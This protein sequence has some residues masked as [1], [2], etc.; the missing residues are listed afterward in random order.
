[1][2]HCVIM[3]LFY[4]LGCQFSIESAD[5]GI[6]HYTVCPKMKLFWKVVVVLLRALLKD[7]RTGRTYCAISQ[8]V[9][10]KEGRVK[11]FFYQMFPMNERYFS[12]ILD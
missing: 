1:M 9:L 4:E 3:H 12:M 7:G 11:T 2:Y 8:Y 5:T 6:F 10:P